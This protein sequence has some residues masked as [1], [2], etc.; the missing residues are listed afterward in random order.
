[1]QCISTG[2]QNLSKV[3]SGIPILGRKGKETSSQLE[4]WVRGLKA[5][6][7]GHSGIDL[8][9]RLMTC[10]DMNQYNT[11]PCS[12]LTFYCQSL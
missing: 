8:P 11:Q 10:F 7:T 5:H 3:T 9:T 2:D 4:K 6:A 12:G 1:M